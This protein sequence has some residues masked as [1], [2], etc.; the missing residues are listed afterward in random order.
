M[1]VW[2]KGA[3]EKALLS[4]KER[5]DA[6]I[7][8]T[9]PASVQRLAEY[10]LENGSRQTPVSLSRGGRRDWWPRRWWQCTWVNWEQMMEAQVCRCGGCGQGGTKNDL[11]HQAWKKGKNQMPVY[12][13]FRD[14]ES[15]CTYYGHSTQVP[16]QNTTLSLNLF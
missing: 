4:T 10:K 1:Q 9:S 5:S 13:R 8:M 7:L 11:S 12:P 6:Q 2:V 16:R 14:T 3:S 15:G